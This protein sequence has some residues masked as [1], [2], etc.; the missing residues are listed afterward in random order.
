[1][2]LIST[3]VFQLPIGPEFKK[4]TRSQRLFSLATHTDVRSLEISGDI[5][6]YLFMEMRAERQWASFRMTPQK[7]VTETMEYNSRLQ[8]Q[9]P[10]AI[11][12]NP[13][14]LLD[15]LIAMEVKIINRVATNNY[16]FMYAPSY[17]FNHLLTATFH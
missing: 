8:K 11:T 14:A 2:A 5:E 1:M 15:K 16:K 4:L 13:R 3:D 10:T 6:F 7:W 9:D 12:K 17:Q